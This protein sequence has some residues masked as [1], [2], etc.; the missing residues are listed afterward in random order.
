M[1]LLQQG[2]GKTEILIEANNAKL[3]EP[4]A[5]AITTSK[6]PSKEK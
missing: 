3:I 5:T 1:S 2:T 6:K 4:A